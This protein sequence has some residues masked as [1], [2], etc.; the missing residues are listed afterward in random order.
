MRHEQVGLYIPARDGEPELLERL[1]G[2]PPRYRV[3]L[4]SVLYVLPEG[5]DPYWEDFGDVIGWQLLPRDEQPRPTSRLAGRPPERPE[6]CLGTPQGQA[7]MLKT[8]RVPFWE[9]PERCVWPMP[10]ARAPKAPLVHWR[11]LGDL[12]RALRFAASDPQALVLPRIAVL[13][14]DAYQDLAAVHR[15]ADELVASLSRTLASPR[16]KQPPHAKWLRRELRHLELAAR[17]FSSSLREYEEALGSELKAARDAFAA[18]MLTRPTLE[19]YARSPRGRPPGPPI[20]FIHV[21][22]AILRQPVALTV[23]G[24]GAS[25]AEPMPVHVGLEKPTEELLASVAALE[26]EHVPGHDIVT[27][28]TAAI[29]YWRSELSQYNRPLKHDPVEGPAKRPLHPASLLSRDAMP[30]G[31]RTRSKKGSEPGRPP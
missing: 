2:A 27:D 11:A 7:E 23:T 24:P 29:R 13:V 5:V 14:G 16:A 19:P 30:R 3:M 22:H 25:R 28:R 18:M 31:V 12:R 4:E 20:L 21:A 26:L 10:Q 17:R 9:M 1:L 6:D 15:K 8:K